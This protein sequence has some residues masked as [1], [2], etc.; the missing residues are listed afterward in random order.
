M[1]SSPNSEITAGRSEQRVVSDPAAD[2]IVSCVSAH[3][4]LLPLLP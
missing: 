1:P 2:L 4:S 3:F